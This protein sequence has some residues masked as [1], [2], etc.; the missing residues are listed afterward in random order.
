MTRHAARAAGLAVT[1]VAVLAGC[2][3]TGATAR[4]DNEARAVLAGEH[5]DALGLHLLDRQVNAYDL[6]GGETVYGFAE[7][8]ALRCSFVDLPGVDP[9]ATE[10]PEMMCAP[11]EATEQQAATA[12]LWGASG[13]TETVL[14]PTNDFRPIAEYVVDPSRITPDLGSASLR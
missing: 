13:T 5:L 3:S 6:G 12:A 11:F 14:E 7:L 8:G 2:A 1:A 10:R 9:A 4:T